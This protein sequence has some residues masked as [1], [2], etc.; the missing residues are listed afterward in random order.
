MSRI[1]YGILATGGNTPTRS[2]DKRT[3]SM[4]EDRTNV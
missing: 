3:G 2:D 4:Y 1:G